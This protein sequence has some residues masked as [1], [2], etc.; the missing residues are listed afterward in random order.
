MPPSPSPLV[1]SSF[2]HS[3]HLPLSPLDPA[4][5]RLSAPTLLFYFLPS[6]SLLH[7]L[8][9]SF[10]H[11]FLKVFFDS[12]P[13]KCVCRVSGCMGGN[14][15]SVTL[16]QVGSLSVQVNESPVILCM[17]PHWMEHTLKPSLVFSIYAI[18]T[19]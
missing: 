2:L 13:L 14:D 11:T 8:C 17:A 4:P 3:Y 18:F 19:A 6:R 10:F 9:V 7:F 15:R 5:I 12:V 16:V 1:L